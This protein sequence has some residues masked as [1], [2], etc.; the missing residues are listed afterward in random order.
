LYFLLHLCPA[1]VFN[2]LAF[3]FFVLF[4]QDF[5]GQARKA[6]ARSQ[7]FGRKPQ[8]VDTVPYRTHPAPQISEIFSRISHLPAFLEC[9]F[10][11]FPHQPRRACSPVQHQYP[12]QTTSMKENTTKGQRKAILLP[13]ALHCPESFRFLF[14]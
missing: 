10:L 1:S 7:C 3:L 13:F 12:S 6:K 11:P 14:L 4:C 8:F 2:L 5:G 9:I